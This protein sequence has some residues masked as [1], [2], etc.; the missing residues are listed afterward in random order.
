M[1][2]S[3]HVKVDISNTPI[4]NQAA[5]FRDKLKD[6]LQTLKIEIEREERDLDKFKEE[7]MTQTLDYNVRS[8]LPLISFLFLYKDDSMFFNLGKLSWNSCQS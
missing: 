1:S 2:G 3:R 4:I 6:R 8:V 7:K 5:L